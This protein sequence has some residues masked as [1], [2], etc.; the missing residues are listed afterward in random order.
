MK[1]F[2]IHVLSPWFSPVVHLN[3]YKSWLNKNKNLKYLQKKFMNI[4][5]LTLIAVNVLVSLLNIDTSYQFYGIISLITVSLLLI[6]KSASL[7]VSKWAFITGL[8][9][10]IYILSSIYYQSTLLQLLFI[11][12]IPI[13]LFLLDRNEIIELGIS[14][15]IPA[16]FFVLLQIP[17]LYLQSGKNQISEQF[18]ALFFIN[19]ACILISVV[20]AIVY[21]FFI[22]E[23]SNQKLQLLVRE[24]QLQEKEITL[25]NQRLLTLN[26][27]LLLSQTELKRTVEELKIR[28]H[29][30]DN[31]VYRV[32][33]D[34]RAPFCSMQGLINLSKNDS[35]IQNLKTYIDLIEKSV[36]KSD[37]FIQSLLN[38]SKILNAELQV[39]IIEF[40]KIIQESFD[41]ACVAEGANSITLEIEINSKPF[42]SDAFRIGIILKNI[43]SNAV[44]YTNPLTD[45][46]FIKVNI[47]VSDLEVR[48]CIADN[49]IGIEK[50]HLP[51]IFNMF[52]RG[53]EKST[54]SGL[55]LYIAQ[56][57]AEKLDGYIEIDS[58][59]NKG[60]TVKVRLQNKVEMQPMS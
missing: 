35:D 50:V 23:K 58:K 41:E 32:S 24:L 44:R 26:A 36:Y 28:N 25:Q 9:G 55:G 34:L 15:S 48:I 18:H 51:K 20:L 37:R 60:T 59:P 27:D 54:G 57:A 5:C 14:L 12:S 49:G 56:Q 38:H 2:I 7:Q 39:D 16:L 3:L 8:N 29:E 33:H 47:S 42:Y 40:E 19:I 45:A 4:I 52:F 17:G 30:L 21:L 31:Y 1:L 13:S 22:Y 10:I 43:I 46:K 53:N 11:L 6:C